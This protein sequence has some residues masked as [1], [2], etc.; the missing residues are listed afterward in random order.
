[1]TLQRTSLL[2]GVLVAIS[3]GLLLVL[4]SSPQ[5]GHPDG[6]GELDIEL[7]ARHFEPDHLYLPTEQPLTLTFANHGDVAHTIAFGRGTVEESGHSAAPAVDMLEGVA[8][9]VDPSGALVHPT[10]QTPYT[11]FRLETDETVTVRLTVP[12]DRAGEWELGCFTARGCYY[13]TGFRADVTVE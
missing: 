3:I 11:G 1:M 6:N 5:A 9:E 12:E 8:V 2:V 10:G 4:P 7:T 13:E